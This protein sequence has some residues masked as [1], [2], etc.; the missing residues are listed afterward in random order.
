MTDTFFHYSFRSYLRYFKGILFWLSLRKITNFTFFPIV[1]K[2]QNTLF[3]FLTYTSAIALYLFPQFCFL[4]G[5]YP[6]AQIF[7]SFRFLFFGAGLFVSN[8]LCFSYYLTDGSFSYNRANSFSATTLFSMC[9]RNI[10][11]KNILFWKMSQLI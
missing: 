10:R 7:F 6:C 2:S 1:L 11:I 5:Y 9:A 3:F 8:P 4:C